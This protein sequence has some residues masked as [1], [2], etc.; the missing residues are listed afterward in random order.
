MRRSRASDR[1]DPA[2]RKARGPGS[3]GTK[4]LRPWLRSGRRQ[5][6]AILRTGSFIRLC[7]SRFRQVAFEAWQSRW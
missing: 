6:G 3:R 5:R 1:P 4:S 7:G 2:P